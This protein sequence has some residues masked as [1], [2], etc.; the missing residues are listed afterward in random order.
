MSKK[1][2]KKT[3]LFLHL[4]QFYRDILKLSKAKAKEVLA[5]SQET[6]DPTVLLVYPAFPTGI[7]MPFF[8]ARDCSIFSFCFFS[9]C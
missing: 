3:P 1:K 4:L 2:K 8:P 7:P 9:L 5:H 6:N